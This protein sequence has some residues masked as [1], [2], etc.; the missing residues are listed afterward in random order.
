MS[1]MTQAHVLGQIA[2]LVFRKRQDN[3]DKTRYSRQDRAMCHLK[4][5]FTRLNPC[6]VSNSPGY[7]DVLGITEYPTWLATLYD[8]HL[9]N[10][11]SAHHTITFYI[12]TSLADSST[13]PIPLHIFSFSMLLCL[14]LSFSLFLIIN[15]FQIIIYEAFSSS[16]HYLWVWVSLSMSLRGY[17]VFL[18]RL[19]A[20]RVFI[21]CAFYSQSSWWKF[22]AFDMTNK[23]QSR[24]F[25]KCN[26]C[27]N[28]ISNR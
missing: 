5:F 12:F 24:Y 22:N 11:K 10:K 19:Y 3:R 4:I 28:L 27:Y 16:V 23:L 13:Q 21:I 1:D 17:L 6:L 8:V 18:Y 2:C 14:S 9:Y 20:W 7:I 25:H 15:N 26:N